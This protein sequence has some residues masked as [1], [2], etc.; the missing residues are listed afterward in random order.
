MSKTDESQPLNPTAKLA[1]VLRDYARADELRRHELMRNNIKPFILLQEGAGSARALYTALIEEKWTS[2]S[3]DAR[4]EIV[5]L[6]MQELQRATG[7]LPLSFVELYKVHVLSRYTLLHHGTSMLFPGFSQNRREEGMLMGVLNQ[8][9]FNW[10]LGRPNQFKQVEI[11]FEASNI[12]NAQPTEILE[13]ISKISTHGMPGKAQDMIR[14]AIHF[15][16]DLV[17]VSIAE[18]RSLLVE[19]WTELKP[20]HDYRTYPAQ[21]LIPGTE[22]VPLSSYS[23]RM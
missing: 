5:D 9:T 19:L 1:D 15:H 14:K 12:P 22:D 3:T 20:K 7:E 6:L 16:D 10:N 8:K 17:M 13:F 11:I 21:K 2:P 18:V 23:V 4:I